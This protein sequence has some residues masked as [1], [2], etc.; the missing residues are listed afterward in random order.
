MTFTEMLP[1]II[2]CLLIVLLVVGIILGIKAIITISKI[3]K[4]VDDV[5]EKVNSLNAFFDMLD[6][7]TRKIGSI[8]DHLFEGT[9]SFLAGLL[10]KRSKKNK[11]DDEDE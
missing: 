11:E 5:N 2:N 3:D 7:A 10:S 8:S 9:L 4:I 6:F 1:I